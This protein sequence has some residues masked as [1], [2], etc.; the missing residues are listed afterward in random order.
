MECREVQALLEE[1]RR[2]AIPAIERD[3]VRAHLDDC[4]RCQALNE[5]AL[6]LGRALRSQLPRHSAPP[7]LRRHVREATRQDRSRLVSLSN[8]WVS[9]GVAAGLALVLTLPFLLSRRSDMMH[10]LAAEVMSEHLRTVLTEE[11]QGSQENY[12]ALVQRLRERTGVP[13][14]WFYA[15]DPEIKLIYVRPILVLGKKGV[16]LVYQDQGGRMATY[17]VFPGEQVTVPASGRVQ[18]AD[19]R[20]YWGKTDGYALLLW[21]Q[22][23]LNCVLVSDWDRDRFLQ[24]FL[25]VRRA[26]EP[27]L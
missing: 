12:K 8:P 18:V 4:P 22:D 9:A 26:A 5:A 20:P 6:A 17:L 10:S 21:K 13:L 24:L 2:D 25:N 7:A 3:G 11:V 16:G 23:G 19:F 14:R 27:A 15:G 1:F